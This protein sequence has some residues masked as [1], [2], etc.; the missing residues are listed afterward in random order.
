MLKIMLI[1]LAGAIGTL[2]RYGLS[3]WITHRFPEPFP[4]GTLVVNLSGCL[5]FGLVV[6]FTEG[7]FTLSEDTRIVLLAG[8]MG[9]FT[10]FSTFAVEASG[11]LRE[12]HYAIAGLHLLAHN[13]L[14]I[15]CIFAGLWL[16]K[17]A[18]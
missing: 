13:A 9:A 14:G 7:R 1:A 12:S 4:I 17:L 8:F 6:A 16:G 18:G 10:T 15:A 3:S 2:A 5:L 11:L